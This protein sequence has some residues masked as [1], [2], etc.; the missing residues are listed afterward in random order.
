MY[1]CSLINTTLYPPR[2]IYDIGRRRRLALDDTTAALQ[3]F[4][5]ADPEEVYC[6]VLPNP[7]PPRVIGVACR[8]SKGE[9]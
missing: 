5:G 2:I 7:A 8:Q 9:G 4:A 1:V 6:L 3:L